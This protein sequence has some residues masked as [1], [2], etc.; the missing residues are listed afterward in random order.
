[1]QHIPNILSGFRIVLIPFIIWQFIVGNTM[2]AGIILLVSA[3]TDFIDGKLARHFGWV[4]DLGKILDPIADKLTQATLSVTLALHLKRYWYF[5]AIIIFK[6]IV[7]LVIGGS[8][9]RKGVRLEG[10]KWFGKVSTF[11]YYLVMLLIILIPTLPHWSV[12]AILTTA[13]VCALIAALLYIPEY[14]KYKALFK[15]QAMEGGTRA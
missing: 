8:L 14:K 4:T 7:M 13:S 10:A 11:V 5:F 1:M 12:V 15:N 9:V 2:I 6:D 3:L